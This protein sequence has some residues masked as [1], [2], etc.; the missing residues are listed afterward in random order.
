M[1]NYVIGPTCKLKIEMMGT[2]NEWSQIG[3]EN[4]ELNNVPVI[5]TSFKIHQYNGIKYKS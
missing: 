3:D 1:I 4:T 2:A 5:G